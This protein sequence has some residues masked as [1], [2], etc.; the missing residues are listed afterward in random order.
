MNDAYPRYARGKGGKPRAGEH[1]AYAAEQ[2]H[3]KHGDDYIVHNFILLRRN[4][5]IISMVD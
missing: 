2:Q 3:G 4:S 5:R 1:G